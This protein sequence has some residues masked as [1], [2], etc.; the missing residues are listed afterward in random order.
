M[1]FIT[2][3][4]LVLSRH[5]SALLLFFITLFF[6]RHLI[7]NAS[8]LTHTHPHALST[9]LSVVF[10]YDIFSS[11]FQLYLVAHRSRLLRVFPLLVK[12]VTLPMLPPPSPC[13]HTHLPSSHAQSPC[14]SFG[15]LSPITL[16]LHHSQ[17][18]PHAPFP[19]HPAFILISH[20][21]MPNHRA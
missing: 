4:L 21:P 19:N 1:F 5:P 2:L 16:I 17:H 12:R 7:L 10:L 8:P 11:P 20:Y 13:L 15:P 6:S 14:L 3:L 18:Q 9:M